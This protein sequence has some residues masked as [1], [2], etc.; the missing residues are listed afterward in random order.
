MPTIAR[1]LAAGAG[2]W[3]GGANQG[4]VAFNQFNLSPRTTR[5]RIHRIAWFASAPAVAPAVQ[6]VTIE[7]RENPVIVATRRVILVD[8][9]SGTSTDPARFDNTASVVLCSEIVPRLLAGGVLAHF[10]LLV[11]TAGIAA[12]VASSLLVD[13]DLEPWPDTSDR[14]GNIVP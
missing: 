13:F 3:P 1:D 2:D 14:D 11:T 10:A 6:R 8:A 5:V 4:L 12:D 7:L 9:I